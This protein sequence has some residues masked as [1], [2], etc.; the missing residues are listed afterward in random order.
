[1][2]PGAWQPQYAGQDPSFATDNNS[3]Q[4]S[5]ARALQPAMLAVRALDTGCRQQMIRAPLA[6]LNAAVAFVIEEQ[7]R[8][9]GSV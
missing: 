1:M 2:G 4:E 5:L 9:Q 6:W 3:G 8:Q 7:C